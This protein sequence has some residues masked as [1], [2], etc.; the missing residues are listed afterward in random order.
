MLMVIRFKDS[1]LFTVQYAKKKKL[2]FA[3][4]TMHVCKNTS[5]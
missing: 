5:I 1:Y 3:L 2:I 4:N